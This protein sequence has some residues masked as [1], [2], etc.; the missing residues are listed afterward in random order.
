MAM[1]ASA[2]LELLLLLLSAWCIWAEVTRPV[3]MV[4]SAASSLLLLLP[5]LF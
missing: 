5:F 1:G 4:T 2:E 3:A